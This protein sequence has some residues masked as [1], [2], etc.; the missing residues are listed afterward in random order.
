MSNTQTMVVTAL[1]DAGVPAASISY[2]VRNDSVIGMFYEL[3]NGLTLSVQWG[4]INYASAQDTVPRFE[5]AVHRMG[6]FYPLRKLDL[7]EKVRSSFEYPDYLQSIMAWA[8]L[9]TVVELAQE[10]SRNQPY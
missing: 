4:P 7:S 2:S 3:A 5:C 10:L 1:I 8:E 9:P 6:Q